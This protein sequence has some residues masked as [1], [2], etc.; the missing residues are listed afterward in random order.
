M[1]CGG[2]LRGASY[3]PR[4]HQGHCT[5]GFAGRAGLQASGKAGQA[6]HHEAPRAGVAL[7]P[8]LFP[9]PAPAFAAAEPLCSY[10]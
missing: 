2:N 10:Q 5:S 4:G 7:S 8:S 6:A 1:P 3:R 9:T